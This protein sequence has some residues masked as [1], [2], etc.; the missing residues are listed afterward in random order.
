MKPTFPVFFT[1]TNKKKSYFKTGSLEC[2][3]THFRSERFC[4]V[5]K[6]VILHSFRRPRVFCD[7]CLHVDVLS[8]LLSVRRYYSLTTRNEDAALL[9]NAVCSHWATPAA[10]LC[11]EANVWWYEQMMFNVVFLFFNCCIFER[12]LLA[13]SKKFLLTFFTFTFST[14]CLSP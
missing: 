3:Y 11:F 5:W 1:I 10:L 9:F 13:Y 6:D 8:A 4:S 2:G 7:Q 12:R 14:W